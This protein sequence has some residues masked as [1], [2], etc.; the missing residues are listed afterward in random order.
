MLAFAE[1]ETN[2]TRTK[3]LDPADSLAVR[4]ATVYATTEAVAI[5]HE[6]YLTAGTSSL[7]DGPLQRCFR[8]IHAASQHFFAGA[9]S[10]MDFGR[11]LMAKCSAD[12]L[13]A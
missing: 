7:R 8:D 11:D 2:V 1:A 6:A 10:T 9:A 5:I 4:Q 13:D 3:Q 12:A